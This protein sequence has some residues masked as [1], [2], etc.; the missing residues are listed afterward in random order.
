MFCP[1]FCVLSVQGL[2][3]VVLEVVAVVV[4]LA[5]LVCT[6]IEAAAIYS[7]DPVFAMQ[8]AHVL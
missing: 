2:S 6:R 1:V 5:L 4:V 3:P 7:I 8:A